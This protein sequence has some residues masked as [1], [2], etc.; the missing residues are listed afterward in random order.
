[1]RCGTPGAICLTC[2]MAFGRRVLA[3]RVLMTESDMHVEKRHGVDAAQAQETLKQQMQEV[4]EAVSEFKSPADDLADLDV[5]RMSEQDISVRL[6]PANDWHILGTGKQG[7]ALRT[8][9]LDGKDVVVKRTVVRGTGRQVDDQVN[10]KAATREINLLKHL[11]DQNAPNVVKLLGWGKDARRISAVLSFV[12]GVPV[13]DLFTKDT[14]VHAPRVFQELLKA[15]TGLCKAGVVHRDTNSD[16]RLVSGSG[17]VTLI[18]FGFSARSGQTTS[19]CSRERGGRCGC[20]LDASY[21][22]SLL[23]SLTTPCGSSIMRSKLF[24]LLSQ[25]ADSLPS[26]KDRPM[27]DE[28]VLRRY[29]R[30][31][32]ELAH[33]ASGT[34]K[35]HS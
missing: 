9:T 13:N 3:T 12:D 7:S 31:S 10:E 33:A 4:Q 15:Y 34:P 28:E 8:K 6:A 26:L 11:Q 30:L 17:D 1:M 32:E 27:P 22:R 29:R 35:N 2:L 18:D 5:K 24:K 21:M 20:D 16:N 19:G 23:F 25:G 14:C